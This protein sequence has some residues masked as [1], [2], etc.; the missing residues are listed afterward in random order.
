MDETATPIS[1]T[2]FTR[3]ET[4]PSKNLTAFCQMNDGQDLFTI[5]TENAGEELRR[6]IEI[7][8]NQVLMT[9]SK[10]YLEML[11]QLMTDT[12]RLAGDKMYSMYYGMMLAV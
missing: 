7:S 1:S 2:P 8:Q 5:Q 6:A 4:Q 12:T 3:S 11:V 10:Y 9:G